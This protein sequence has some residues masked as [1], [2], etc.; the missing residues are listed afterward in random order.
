M[1]EAGQTPR[2]NDQAET[3]PLILDGRTGNARL[4][5]ELE[6]SYTTALG[7][8]LDALQRDAVTRAAE[9]T[10]IARALRTARLSGDL[11]VKPA[12]I[13]K[14]ENL[15]DRARRQL[16][17]GNAPSRTVRPIRERLRAQA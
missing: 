5:R 2:N 11:S 9:L 4:V 8:T 6:Q 16:R 15:A 13:T 7:G 1:L 3:K 10:A 14:A 12:E 17:I